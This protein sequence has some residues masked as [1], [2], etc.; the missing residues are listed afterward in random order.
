MTPGVYLFIRDDEPIYIGCTRDLSKRPKKR[1]KGHS[2]RYSAIVESDRVRLLPC[3]SYIEAQQFEEQLIRRLQP[4][5]NSRNPVAPA[6][7][8]RT[9]KIIKDNW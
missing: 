5:Y 6:N 3:D 2:A 4:I 9:W 1:D 7:M 8:Q